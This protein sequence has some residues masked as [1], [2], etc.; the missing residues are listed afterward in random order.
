MSDSL[1]SAQIIDKYRSHCNFYAKLDFAGIGFFVTL[2]TFLKFD[3][4]KVAFF[5]SQLTFWISVWSILAAGGLLLDYLMLEAWRKAMQGHS[6]EKIIR[7]WSRVALIQTVLHCSV[8]GALVG[9]ATGVI[10]SV[11]EHVK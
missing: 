10:Q 9:A 6:N 11:S 2:M 3:E 5:A 1:H 7:R 8:V 4:V